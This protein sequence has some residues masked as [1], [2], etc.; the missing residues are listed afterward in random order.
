MTNLFKVK[1]YKPLTI[2]FNFS[3][4]FNKKKETSKSQKF[5]NNIPMHGVSKG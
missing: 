3:I 2:Y 4:C 5:P 1:T